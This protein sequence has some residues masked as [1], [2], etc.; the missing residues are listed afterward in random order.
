MC[1]FFR[2]ALEIVETAENTKFIIVHNFHSYLPHDWLT[3]RH[4]SAFGSLVRNCKWRQYLPLRE[5]LKTIPRGRRVPCEFVRNRYGPRASRVRAPICALS[6]SWI[7]IVYTPVHKTHIIL[8]GYPLRVS[9]CITHANG[10]GRTH[11]KISR[12]FLR[13]MML[14]DKNYTRCTRNANRKI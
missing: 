10:H 11:G 12:H 9:T 2:H 8:H 6:A 14:D 7:Y 4:L 3:I 5:R 13:C 1:H